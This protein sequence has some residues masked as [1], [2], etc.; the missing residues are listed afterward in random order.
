MKKY[1]EQMIFGPAHMVAER[2]SKGF[3]KQVFEKGTLD[4]RVAGSNPKDNNIATKAMTQRF[5]HSHACQFVK[6]AVQHG[7][8]MPIHEAL[9]LHAPSI[10]SI[11]RSCSTRAPNKRAATTDRY[12]DYAFGSTSG[13]IGSN[14]F[15]LAAICLMA[16]DEEDF[17]FLKLEN[18]TIDELIEEG[19]TRDC[20]VAM[21]QKNQVKFMGRFNR[22]WSSL[23]E[24]F[25]LFDPDEGQS[26]K[27]NVSIQDILL[28]T[29][30]GFTSLNSAKD[31]PS[32]YAIKYW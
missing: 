14:I 18:S 16:L 15:F 17:P 8:S 23:T 20:L 31:T 28:F 13:S 9:A 25:T 24:S 3:K 22:E 4:G 12:P 26:F 30:S 5:F 27:K 1:I 21:S 7:C 19:Y 6:I 11:I 29:A 2:L 32:D 10:A